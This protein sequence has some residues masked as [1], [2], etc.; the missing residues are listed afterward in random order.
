MKMWHQILSHMTSLK[1]FVPR[2][3]TND[4]TRMSVLVLLSMA[5]LR[6]ALPPLL[7]FIPWKK[8]NLLLLLLLPV[9]LMQW[10]FP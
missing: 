10:K 6:R 4:V 9:K 1:P 3:R 8:R 2:G 7:L 5:A